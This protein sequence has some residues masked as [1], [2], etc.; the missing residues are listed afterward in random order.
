MIAQSAVDSKQNHPPTP[1]TV[2]YA[3]STNWRDKENLAADRLGMSAHAKEFFTQETTL[4]KLTQTILAGYRVAPGTFARDYRHADNWRGAQLAALDYDQNS[5]ADLQANPIIGPHSFL[6]HSTPS[7]GVVTDKNPDGKLRSRAWFVLPERVT[8]PE[9]IELINEGLYLLG[10]LPADDRDTTKSAAMGFFGSTNRIEAPHINTSAVLPPALVR[11]AIATARRER[12]SQQV[13]AID[14]SDDDT[15]GELAA[16]IVSYARAIGWKRRGDWIN[17]PCPFHDDHEP[18]AGIAVNSGVLNCFVC[19]KIEPA[20]IADK[21]HIDTT[22]Y[23]QERRQRRDERIEQELTPADAIDGREAMDALPDAPASVVKTQIYTS[24]IERPTKRYADYADGILSGELQWAWVLPGDFRQI[25]YTGIDAGIYRGFTPDELSEAAAD[26]G[27]AIS[28]RAVRN[29]QAE[30]GILVD[31][32][33]DLIEEGLSTKSTKNSRGR[34]NRRFALPDRQELRRIIKQYGFV[35]LLTIAMTDGPD[36]LPM[37]AK[38]ELLAALDIHIDNDDDLIAAL[39]SI[40]EGL[41][42]RDPEFKRQIDRAWGRFRHWYD[43]LCHDLDCSDIADDFQIDPDLQHADTAKTVFAAQMA[44]IHRERRAGE[45]I[46]RNEWCMLTGVSNGSL[47]KVL[48]LSGTRR[49]GG[50]PPTKT[51]KLDANNP[52]DAPSAARKLH[53]E[54]GGK[55]R[56]IVF[57]DG[58]PRQRYNGANLQAAVMDCEA[59]YIEYSVAGAWEQYTP[60]AEEIALSKEP[61]QSKSAPDHPHDLDDEQPRKPR[62]PHYEGPNVDPVIARRWFDG[63][64]EASGWRRDEGEYWSDPARV[65]WPDHVPTLLQALTGVQIPGAMGPIDEDETMLNMHYMGDKYDDLQNPAD[66][67][68][69]ERVESAQNLSE[70]DISGESTGPAWFCD[71]YWKDR[72]TQPKR[73]KTA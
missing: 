42:A 35:R 28:A 53:Q 46:S 1:A 45:D 68:A 44:R 24:E 11:E 38:R 62:R 15:G 30:H 37:Y 9:I 14:W 25:L 23:R 60:T 54:I 57:G 33:T 66:I 70:P 22:D 71:W 34:P 64:L 20:D 6:I 69:L 41:K 17:G 52:F 36:V 56:W 67:G 10:G 8:D 59:V 18:S 26:R 61:A 31:L 27:L 13:I 16:R 2:R 58:R 63:L 29:L 5:V 51:A 39:D 19:G 47:K 73:R 43:Q 12:E 48:T 65:L 4:Q 32:D 55:P 3:V 40:I 50:K 21:W 72:L 7:S 49:V